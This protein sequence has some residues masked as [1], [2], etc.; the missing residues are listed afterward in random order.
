MNFESERTE[1]IV[2][3]G[4]IAG[5]Q[6][7]SISKMFY[8]AFPVGFVETQHCEVKGKHAQLCH[9]GKFCVH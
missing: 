3:K 1:N 4:G 7:F 8:K 5:I 6:H 2:E 9:F